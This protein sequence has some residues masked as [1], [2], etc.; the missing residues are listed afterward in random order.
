MAWIEEV[1]RNT[2]TKFALNPKVQ[3]VAPATYKAF[4]LADVHNNILRVASGDTDIGSRTF[5]IGKWSRELCRKYISRGD[6]KKGKQ[7]GCRRRIYS[8]S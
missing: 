7:T 6:T 1:P 4:R 5:L 8:S 3:V 2:A